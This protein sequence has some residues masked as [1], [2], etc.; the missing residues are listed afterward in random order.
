LLPSHNLSLPRVQI[1]IQLLADVD[2]HVGRIER[3]N[4]LQ[5]AGVNAFG[6][7]AGERLL[8]H[9][10]RLD[11]DEGNGDRLVGAPAG[12]GA[13]MQ[14]GA[15]AWQIAFVDVHPDVMNAQVADYE[16]RLAGRS[17]DV[18]TGPDVLLN[19]LAVDWSA[20]YQPFQLGFGLL[21]RGLRLR[22]CDA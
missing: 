7:G 9:D 20:N 22:H 3:V 10:H 5:H 21:N 15:E 1:H 11:A 18:L 2:R 16:Q 6:A 19:D 14:T 4:C 8:R 13:T 12:H 17:A